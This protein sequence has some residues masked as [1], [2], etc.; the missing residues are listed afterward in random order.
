MPIPREILDVTH[1]KNTVVIAY[2]REKSYTLSASISAAETQQT[3]GYQ[4]QAKGRSTRAINMILD[5]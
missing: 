1:P 4:K 3:A 2:G 5:H